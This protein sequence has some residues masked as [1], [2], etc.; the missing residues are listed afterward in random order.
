MNLSD[1]RINLSTSDAP[2]N[3]YFEQDVKQFIK[4]LKEDIKQGIVRNNV[5]PFDWFCDRV[6][7]LAGKE[8]T[9]QEAK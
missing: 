7:K 6:D 2:L 8:L 5:L 9:E 1:K 4:D 3:I